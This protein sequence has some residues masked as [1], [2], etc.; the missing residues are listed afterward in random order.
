MIGSCNREGDA[1]K[2]KPDEIEDSDRVEVEEEDGDEADMLL[3]FLDDDEDLYDEVDDEFADEFWWR[4]ECN[5]KWSDL[6]N[7]LSQ[8]SHLYG[9]SPECF[10]KC[11]V[12]SSLNLI[13]HL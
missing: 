9:L 3:L 13:F 7:F 2:E 6:E 11:R 5:C 4:L 12:N 10:L 1:E 8:F